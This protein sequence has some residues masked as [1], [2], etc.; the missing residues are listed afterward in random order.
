MK[1]TIFIDISIKEVFLYLLCDFCKS[2]K[3]LPQIVN[4]TSN[5]ISTKSELFKNILLFVQKLK[6]NIP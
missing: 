2:M 1:I 4:K 5:N 6:K 3:K